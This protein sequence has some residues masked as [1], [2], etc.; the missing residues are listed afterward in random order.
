MKLIGH[1]PPAGRRLGKSR[2]IEKGA[3]VFRK[4]R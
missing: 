4:A 1:P 2:Y 3:A